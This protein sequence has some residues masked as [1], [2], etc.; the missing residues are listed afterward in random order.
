MAKHVEIAGGLEPVN[1]GEKRVLQAFVERLPA[2]YRVFSNVQV[3]HKQGRIDDCDLIVL[4]PK[5]VLVVEV[6]D[7]KGSVIVNEHSHYVNGE[8]RANPIIT[9]EFKAKKIKSRLRKIQ[10][11]KNVSVDA[12]VVLAR[13]PKSLTIDEHIR[14]RVFLLDDV[15][16][17]LCDPK[18]F[19]NRPPALERRKRIEGTLNLEPRKT[20]QKFGPCTVRHLL[21][22]VPGEQ[23]FSGI[24]TETHTDVRIRRVFLPPLGDASA[25]EALKRRLVRAVKAFDSIQDTARV[26]NPGYIDTMDDGAL[27]LVSPDRNVVSLNERILEDRPLD[28][29]ARVRIVKDVADGLA[30][31]GRAGIAHRNLTPD[32]IEISPDGVARI[33]DLDSVRLGESTGRTLVR[34]GLDDVDRA[35]I[36]AEALLDPAAAS[37]QSDR[38]SL[39]A[40]IAWLWPDTDRGPGLLAIGPA[41]T[42]L[43]AL[44]PTLAASETAKRGP[45]PSAVALICQRLLDRGAPQP[46]RPETWPPTSIDTFEIVGQILEGE[47]PAFEALDRVSGERCFLKLYPEAD[48]LAAV[49]RQH[50]ALVAAQGPGVIR[51]RHAGV[52]PYGA[53]LV[54]EL[55]DGPDLR[56][57]LDAGAQ[58]SSV[59]V[60][61]VEGLVEGLA[62]LHA[63]TGSAHGDVKPANLFAGEAD[64]TLVDF[65]LCGVDPSVVGGTAGYVPPDGVH[66]IDP[67]RDLYASAVV[68]HELLIG[69]LPDGGP[70]DDLPDPVLGFLTKALA[71]ARA[72]RFRDADEMLAA[73]DHLRRSLNGFTVGPSTIELHRISTEHDL[74]S[75]A[76]VPV[77]EARTTTY[78]VTIPG[79]GALDI[80]VYRQVG[81]DQAWIQ[82]TESHDAAPLLHGLAG[83]ARITIKPTDPTGRWWM[84]LMASNAGDGK[85][86]SKKKV[87]AAE[88]D[89]LVG[90][91]VAAA[92]MAASDV[93]YGTRETVFADDGPRRGYLCVEFPDIEG[94]IAVTAYVIARVLPLVGLDA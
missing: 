15:I 66:V 61:M 75:P 37:E 45:E 76:K 41:P 22:E 47:H 23:R 92:L 9:T 62:R 88:L 64:L 33:T 91:D 80:T 21:F 55:L 63:T 34:S 27:V 20:P 24:H 79:S 83:R 12:I 78:R 7:L 70:S 35:F 81:G 44:V 89:T 11:I 67:D 40:L 30:A 8:E 51:A 59:A 3:A 93:R 65:D 72:D 31:L 18:A 58:Y 19:G 74:T 60:Q 2:E 87:S 6:K 48:G 28:E 82:P 86:P 16:E 36:A 13:A 10:E 50:A 4:T 53:Y 56:A 17:R 71:P 14:D 73:L 84:E 85:R 94:P 1:D 49:Q 26:A 39:G 38:H 25:F 5:A 69:T 29:E 57:D 52:S 90:F 54:T 46:P 77:P 43:A 68:L 32:A 42:D